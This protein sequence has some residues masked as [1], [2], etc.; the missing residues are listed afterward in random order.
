MAIKKLQNNYTTPE[1]SKLLLKSGLHED[2]ADCILF[3]P[4]PNSMY[5]KEILQHEE[6]YS[7]IINHYKE[8]GSTMSYLPCWSVGRLQ[9]IAK[10]CAKDKEYYYTSL[11]TV[12]HQEDFVEWWV[13]HF[14]LTD[15]VLFDFSKLD[16]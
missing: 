11:D 9:E 14:T 13:K 12:A 8:V 6:T 10:I 2:S 15:N 4:T 1:Q 5:E 16:D 3:A 7:K